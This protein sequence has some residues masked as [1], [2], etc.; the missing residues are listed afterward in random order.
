M[1]YERLARAAR[2][3][4]KGLHIECNPSTGAIDV[5]YV[6]SQPIFN[7]L[8]FKFVWFRCSRRVPAVK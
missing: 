1:P 2:S 5:L 6:E 8:T 7:L 3:L 4:L